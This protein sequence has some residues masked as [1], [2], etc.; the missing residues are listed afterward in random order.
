[1]VE[2]SMETAFRT[3]L[4]RQFGAAIDMVENTVLPYPASLWRAP[5]ERTLRS[6]P[7]TGRRSILVLNLSHTL[8]A[9]F[10]SQRPT[11]RLNLAVEASGCASGRSWWPIKRMRST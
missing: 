7:I 6:P 2:Q 3:V 5:L 9:R 11:R 10:A 8:L 1:M 4:W